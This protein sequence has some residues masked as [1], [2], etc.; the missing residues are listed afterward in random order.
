MGAPNRCPLSNPAEVFEGECLARHDGFLDEGF[1]DTVIDVFL[2]AGFA[3]PRLADAPLGVVGATLL[4]ALPPAV[5]ASAHHLNLLAA[6]A[7]PVAIGGQ[8]DNA[9]VY[10]EY[11]ICIGGWSS[12]RERGQVG[13]FAALRDMQVVDAT[14]AS[15]PPD[16][17]RPADLPR[18]IS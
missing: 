15:T 1:T 12:G 4:Q 3:L 16:Q 7:L 8:I 5:V 9:Q 18:G 13:R 14:V 10:A 2:E 11:P 17:I 6:E